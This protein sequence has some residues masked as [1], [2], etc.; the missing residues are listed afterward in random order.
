MQQRFE[1]SGLART[2][3]TLER[4]GDCRWVYRVWVGDGRDYAGVAGSGRV[5]APALWRVGCLV[6]CLCCCRDGFG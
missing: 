2:S 6:L 4:D 3:Q 5:A 1:I